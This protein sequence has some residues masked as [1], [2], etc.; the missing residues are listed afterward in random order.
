MDEKKYQSSY[1][2]LRPPTARRNLRLPNVPFNDN[3]ICRNLAF[4]WK[5][6]IYVALQGKTISFEFITYNTSIE[7]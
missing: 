3:T 6:L 1:I 2:V 7:I 5:S 4:S